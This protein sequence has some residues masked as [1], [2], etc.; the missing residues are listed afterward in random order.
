MNHF[1]TSQAK[2]LVEFHSPYHYPPQAYELIGLLN[3]VAKR[4]CKN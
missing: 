1:V 3:T 4:I 2:E